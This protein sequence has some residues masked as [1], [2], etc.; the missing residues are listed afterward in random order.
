[1]LAN[2][3]LIRI[4]SF[5]I[6][7]IKCSKAGLVDLIEDLRDRVVYGSWSLWRIFIGSLVGCL[8]AIHLSLTCSGHFIIYLYCSGLHLVGLCDCLFGFV[9]LSCRICNA[10]NNL[11]CGLICFFRY[12]FIWWDGF[13]EF[14]LWLNLCQ[15]LALIFWCWLDKFEA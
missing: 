6:S 12:S 11:L 3:A 9:L 8:T 5:L 1:M 14:T 4:L 2:E 13:I 10:L 7:T 15:S